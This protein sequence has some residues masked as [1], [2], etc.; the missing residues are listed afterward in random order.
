MTGTG[1]LRALLARAAPSAALRERVSAIA[2]QLDRRAPHLLWLII[3]EGGDGE[4]A[5][6]TWSGGERS[7]RI[8][9]LVA[10]R[11]RVLPSDAETMRALAGSDTD[12][13]VLAHAL[14]TDVLGRQALSRRFY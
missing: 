1:T 4:L 13:D 8:A 7:P 12:G 5:L 10:R 11:A 6:A 2:R 9:A 3:A 14:W